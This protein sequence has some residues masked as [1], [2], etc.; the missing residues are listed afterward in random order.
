MTEEAWREGSEKG[1]VEHKDRREEKKK[2]ANEGVVEGI[3][4]G[5]KGEASIKT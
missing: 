2:N 4:V 3:R 5:D 1:G